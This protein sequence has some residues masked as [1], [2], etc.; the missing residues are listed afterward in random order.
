MDDN[1][2]LLGN[3]S[4]WGM[5]IAFKMVYVLAWTIGDASSLASQSLN[6]F[7]VVYSSLSS[8]L[9]TWSKYNIVIRCG[10]TENHGAASQIFGF[11]PLSSVAFRTASFLSCTYRVI[12]ET[13]WMLR[14]L[15]FMTSFKRGPILW[16]K[17][18]KC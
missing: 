2:K 12:L 1:S 5:P 18:S 15:K 8:G 9:L 3:P 10:T 11:I 17:S 13:E 4:W 6:Q 14:L 16:L 7:D